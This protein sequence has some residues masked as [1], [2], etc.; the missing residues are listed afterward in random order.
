VAGTGPAR[1]VETPD[2]RGRARP[3]LATADLALAGLFLLVAAPILFWNLGRPSL[4][5]DEATFAQTAREALRDG[6]WLPLTF[7]GE[8]F[9]F[10]P[11]L[12]VFAQALLYAIAGESELT[13]RLIDAVAGLVTALLVLRFGSRVFDRQTGLVAALLL[14]SAHGYVFNH[15]VRS[16]SLDGLLVLLMTSALFLY[17]EAALGLRPARFAACGL[18]LGAG[19][20]CKW[21][22]PLLAVAIMALDWAVLGRREP[23]SAGRGLLLVLILTMV[24]CLPWVISMTAV[25]GFPYLEALWFYDVARISRP[26]HPSHLHGLGFYFTTL[27]AD[28][29]FWPVLLLPAAGSLWVATRSGDRERARGLAFLFV[30]AGL[31]LG[32]FSVPVSKLPWYVYP[33][34]PALTLLVARGAFVLW[35]RRA[36]ARIALALLLGGL[37]A[38]RLADAARTSAHD[39]RVIEMHRFARYAHR[40]SGANVWIDEALKLWL[41]FREWNYYYANSLPVRWVAPPLPPAPRDGCVFLVTARPDEFLPD[42]APYEHSLV[43]VANLAPEEAPIAIVDLCTGRLPSDW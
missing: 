7:R 30:W 8:S 5:G 15:G 40:L 2:R 1:I 23:A 10:H 31:I 42:S 18:L 33:L 36:S 17:G 22:V 37:L 29:G 26:L 21:P 35:P 43:R 32:A 14:V 11:P 16:G 27:F 4:M 39:T 28:F 25:T 24:A 20:L 6:H 34:Y 38:Y 41:S 3:G 9:A 19:M 13:T 12:K